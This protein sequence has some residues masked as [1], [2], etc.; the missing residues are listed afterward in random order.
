MLSPFDR[1]VRSSA[2]TIINAKKQ[3][4]VRPHRP[5]RIDLTLF[6]SDSHCTAV[7]S[8]VIAGSVA[9]AVNRV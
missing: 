4:F 7:E 1:P 5:F 8:S 2:A 9:P 3:S 6:Y